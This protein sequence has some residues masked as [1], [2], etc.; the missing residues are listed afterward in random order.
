MRGDAHK[1][2][3][4]LK[5]MPVEDIKK[6]QYLRETAA[7]KAFYQ[8]LDNETL[9]LIYFQIVKEKNGIGIIPIFATA[10]PWL[11]FLF[12]NPLENFLF[13]DG[14]SNW[15]I[16]SI[17]YLIL[18]SISLVLHFKEKAWANVHME[19]IQDILTRRN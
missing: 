2:Y 19:I 5:E 6:S 18:L 17:V 1:L 8:L 4:Q 13:H 14:S 7:I 12:A 16:F 3:L 11:L 15:M 10:I 9:R